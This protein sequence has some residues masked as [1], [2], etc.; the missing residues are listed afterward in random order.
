MARKKLELNTACKATFKDGHTEEFDSIE[1]A[2]EKT[3]LTVASIK[4]RCNKPGS[5][6]KDNTTFEWKDDYT[7][8]YYRAK[9]SKSK[10]SN[11]EYQ[12]IKELT[13]L[14]YSGLKTSR[15]ES[16]NLDNAKIDV[17]D[18]E[19]QL[20][21][22]IQCKATANTPNIEKITSECPYKDKPLVVFWKKQNSDSK[23]HEYVLVP[24]KYFYTLLINNDLK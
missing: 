14:G 9:K 11:F 21:C 1:E 16:K 22:Y 2:S 13:N 7:A 15:G 19:N 4:I 12:I 3:G 17:A 24:K 6:G 10:G 8:R 20:S 5:G 18:T 23:E